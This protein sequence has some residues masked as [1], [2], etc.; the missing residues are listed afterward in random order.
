M[1]E[2]R[3]TALEGP[4][5]VK[6]HARYVEGWLALDPA[7]LEDYLSRSAARTDCLGIRGH[8]DSC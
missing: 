8:S 3:T 4:K 2:G 7:S 6:G 5:W 1:P